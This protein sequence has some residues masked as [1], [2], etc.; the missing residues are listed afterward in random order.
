MK[1]LLISLSNVGGG[2]SKI[3]S[4]LHSNLLKNG[5]DVE[6]AIFSGIPGD[7]IR[8][9]N[10]SKFSKIIFRLKN[11][12]AKLLFL[13]FKNPS[14]DY[15]SINVFPS[16][17]LRFINNSD[18]DIVHF[19]WIGAEMIS[20]KQ[21]SKI[22]KTIIWTLH[23]AWPL[24]GSYHID[25]IDFLFD[26][27]TIQAYKMKKSNLLERMTLIRKKKYLAQ[28]NICFTSPSK[29][30]QEKYEA[31][32]YAKDRSSCVV[33]P[34]FIDFTKWLPIDK[35]IARTNLNIKSSKVLL[36]F[37]AN[38]ATTSFNKGFHFVLELMKILPQDKFGYIIFGNRDN[39]RFDEGQEVFFMGEISDM[40]KMRNVYSAGDI[41][42]V[43]SMSE[44]FSLVSLESIA[45]NT[46]VLAFN[47][48][49]IKD[50]VKHKQNGFLAEK[51]SVNSLKSGIDWIVANDLTDLP[52]SVNCFSIKTVTQ[53][54]ESLYLEKFLESRN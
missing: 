9:L 24:N 25:P 35:N 38:N 3:V 26:N 27:L 49:G 28:K 36:T 21:I 37:G 45:C 47:S 10:S 8:I 17:L 29:W 46:P 32:F 50:V 15:L 39:I 23:D 5:N 4:S 48:S 41:T 43:P 13:F 16:K 2:A 34:N 31:S 54:Y 14:N 42:I 22:N 51:F 52:E 6:L 18:A 40:E 11:Y 53:Q 33:I 12:A 19:H 1:V 44:S 20:L 30:L 7:K